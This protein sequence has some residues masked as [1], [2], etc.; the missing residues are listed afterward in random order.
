MRWGLGV[1]FDFAQA[2]R[3]VVGSVAQARPSRRREGMG[4]GNESHETIARALPLPNPSPAGRG[5]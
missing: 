1:A 4:E 5:A 3:A 2:E